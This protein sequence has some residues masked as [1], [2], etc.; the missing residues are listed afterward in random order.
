MSKSNFPAAAIAALLLCSVA[1]PLWAADAGPSPAVAKVALAAQN[2]FTAKR[3]GEAIAKAKEILAISGKT[4]YDTFF[5]YRLMLLAYQGQGN[6]AEMLNAWQ[7]MLDS[8]HPS[9]AEQNQ[10]TKNMFLTAAG[11]KNYPQA[12]EYGNRLIRSG[13]AEPN[14]YVVIADSMD[15]QG[16]SA[17]ALKFL[18]DYV[19]GLERGSQKP[20]EQTLAMLRAWQDKH[21]NKSA[22]TDTMEKLVVHYPKPEYWS[23]LLY[24]AGRDAKLT[25]RQ[26]M[27]LF[28]LKKDTGNLKRCEDFT[29]Y[30]ETAIDA[31]IPGEGQTVIEQG[32]A[33]KACVEKTALDKLQRMNATA[34]REVAA[35]KARLAK[36]EV[37]AKAAKTGQ[38]DVE[39]GATQFGYGEYAR[40]VEALSRGIG[41]GGLKNLDDAQLMLGI[42]Q[43]RANNKSE[44]VKT[45]QSIKSADPLTQRIVK[46]WI[47]HASR[48]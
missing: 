11:I 36:L 37:D 31:G 21:G 7:G 30:A 5:A 17:E 14:T 47:L 16:K 44:A 9:S 20:P 15:K 35:D 27:Q 38:L 13:G 39:L 19:S 23:L 29:E 32:V 25:E 26:R 22:A 45:F 12:V 33:A 10:I 24:A 46:L 4:Q 34:T 6:Q 1:V 28:R 18:S 42:A 8:G 3:Y 2:E 41:K 43:F 40:S 48:P